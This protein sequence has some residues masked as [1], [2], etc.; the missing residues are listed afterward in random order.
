MSNSRSRVGAM[1]SARTAPVKAAG[2]AAVIPDMAAAANDE[3]NPLCL[4]A[5]GMAIFFVVAAGLVA[6][7]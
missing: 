5:A 1:T 3:I 2:R 4:I 6:A 7:S